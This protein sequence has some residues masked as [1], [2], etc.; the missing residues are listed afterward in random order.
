MRGRRLQL[1]DIDWR[2]GEVVIRGK[3]DRHDR[4]PLPPDV[5]LALVGYLQDARPCEVPDRH[6]FITLAA[7]YRALPGPAISHFVAR[8][9]A[10]AGL[11][12]IG[13]H[14]LRHTAATMMLAQGVPLAQ[15]KQVLRHRHPATLLVLICA[16][17][18][19]PMLRETGWPPGLSSFGISPPGGPLQEQTR[20]DSPRRG[21]PAD[22]RRHAGSARRPGSAPAEIHRRTPLLLRGWLATPGLT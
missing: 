10:S 17:L 20:S 3:R 11:G 13:A 12:E 6:V 1:E 14:R 4:L 21:T 5:G 16:A 2:A 7:P 15:I 18:K 8:C 9:G 22:R 19:A